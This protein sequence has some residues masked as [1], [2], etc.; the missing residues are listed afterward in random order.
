MVA[1]VL[2]LAM[3]PV[4][5]GDDVWRYRWEGA[6]QLHGYNPYTLAPDSPALAGLRDVEWGRISH[7]NEAA[8]YPP[9]A[10]MVFRWIARGGWS[11]VGV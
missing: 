4:L 9:L 7:Q 3:L 11:G 1:A 6:I 5:P 10:E 8:I 2:R